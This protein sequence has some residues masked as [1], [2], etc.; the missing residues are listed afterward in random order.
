MS[1]LRKAVIVLVLPVLLFVLGLVVVDIRIATSNTWLAVLTSLFAVGSGYVF[2][3]A[4][5]VALWG[6]MEARH[7]PYWW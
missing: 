4:C 6:W 7:R 5:K 2:F 3:S 1:L